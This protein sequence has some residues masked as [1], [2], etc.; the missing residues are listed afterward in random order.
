MRC[1]R[2]FCL[3][4]NECVSVDSP[5]GFVCETK[6]WRTKNKTSSVERLFYN[7]FTFEESGWVK[8][9]MFF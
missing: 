8:K 5:L 3:V 1:T 6:S 7:S 2:I 9:Y 4:C